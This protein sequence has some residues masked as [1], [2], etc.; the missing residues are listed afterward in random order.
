MTLSFDFHQI[1][2]QTWVTTAWMMISMN[3]QTQ[4]NQVRRMFQAMF[5]VNFELVCKNWVFA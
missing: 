2:M 5:N 3:I 1:R 4:S